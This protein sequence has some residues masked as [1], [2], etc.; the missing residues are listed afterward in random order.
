MT[1]A[2]EKG[3]RTSPNSDSADS[4][5]HVLGGGDDGSAV[6]RDA[7]VMEA[8]ASRYHGKAPDEIAWAEPERQTRAVEEY[9]AALEGETEPN[10]ERKPPKVISP[11]D[12]CSAWTAKA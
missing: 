10:P 3:L 4:M 8:N 12:P 7:S 9:L 5:D 2:V 6:R 1:D 11:S